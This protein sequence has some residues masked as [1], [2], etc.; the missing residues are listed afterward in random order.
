MLRVAFKME[1]KQRQNGD[2]TKACLA[3]NDR[4]PEGKVWGLEIAAQIWRDGKSIQ[5]FATLPKW[6]K[7]Q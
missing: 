6:P 1:A 3:D 2:K 7:L 5:Q 4:L